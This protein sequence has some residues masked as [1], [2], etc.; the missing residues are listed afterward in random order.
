MDDSLAIDVEE[1]EK[2]TKALPPG[3]RQA[4]FLCSPWAVSIE[5]KAQGGTSLERQDG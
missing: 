3:L 1:E 5:D 2:S 4:H